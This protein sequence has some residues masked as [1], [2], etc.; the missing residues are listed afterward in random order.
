VRATQNIGP[1][2]F[3]ATIIRFGDDADAHRQ[4]EPLRQSVRDLDNLPLAL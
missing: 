3:S 2:F 4:L 1:S